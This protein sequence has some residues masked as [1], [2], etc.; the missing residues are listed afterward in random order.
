MIIFHFQ[1]DATFSINIGETD[2]SSM[3]NYL[4]IKFELERRDHGK[5]AN[6]SDLSHV[7]FSRFIHYFVC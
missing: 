7:A 6:H 2:E 4:N 1:S 5:K 3:L